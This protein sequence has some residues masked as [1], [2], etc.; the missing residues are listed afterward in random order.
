MNCP[1]AIDTAVLADYWLSLLTASEEENVELHLF[2][3][4][5]CASRLREVITLAD[6]I[7]NLARSGSLRIILSE[8]FLDQLAADDVSIRRYSIPAGGLIQC[9]V[10]ADDDLLVARLASHCTNAARVD[11][12]ICDERG[13]EQ[14]RLPDI[15]I[16]PGANHLIYQESITFAKA[17]P[18][19][20]MIARLIA[21]DEADSEAL[22]SE[23]AFN[24]TRSMPG[25]AAW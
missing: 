22:I 3:C 23:Y 13:I 17:M 19:N 8:A 18:S 6:G 10:T 2:E 4:D 21:F 7:R 1:D 12:S 25:P 15:P 16:Q 14:V 11:L 9:T 24:H 20:K 5:R